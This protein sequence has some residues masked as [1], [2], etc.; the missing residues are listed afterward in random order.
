[1]RVISTS[2]CTISSRPLRLARP[3]NINKLQKL[4]ARPRVFTERAGHAA[5]DHRDSALVN[6]AGSHALVNRVDHDAYAARFQDVVDAGCD[7]RGE[8]L[9]H[10]KA[11]RVA[12][13]DAR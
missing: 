3:A 4:R 12:F 2:K 11:P 7:L 9:L 10:L 8:L 13:D 1:M 5:G 6:T